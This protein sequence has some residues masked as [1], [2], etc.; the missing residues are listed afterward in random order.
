LKGI[1]RLDEALE[2]LNKAIEINDR[3][4]DSFYLKAQILKRQ[5]KIEELEETVRK[6]ILINPKH[7]A[8]EEF[9]VG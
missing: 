8:K 1:G 4:E 5:G 6:L 2:S 9:K 3:N 7:I